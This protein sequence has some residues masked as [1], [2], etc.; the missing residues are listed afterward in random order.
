[1]TVTTLLDVVANDGE[2][3]LREAI[4]RVTDGTDPPGT[5]ITFDPGLAGGV[6]RLTQGELTLSRSMTIDGDLDGDGVPDI[7]LS[8]DAAGDDTTDAAGIT[9][10][11]ASAQA[12]TLTDNSRV[13]SVTEGPV[14]LTGLVITGGY[15]DL[16]GGIRNPVNAGGG[17]RLYADTTI[18]DSRIEG[19]GVAGYS[20]VGGGLYAAPLPAGGPLPALHI[21]D[22]TIA[23]NTATDSGG[24][25]GGIYIRAVAA[26]FADVAIDDN[27]AADDAGGIFVQGGSL[28]MTGGSLSG[29]ATAPGFGASGGGM[30]NRGFTRIDGTRIEDNTAG[31]DGGGL[32]LERSAGIANAT[33]E[34]N[35]AGGS[36]GGIHATDR[37]LVVSSAILGNS[38][39]QDG[40]GIRDRGADD[41]SLLLNTTV[42]GNSAGGDGGGLYVQGTLRGSP[43]T[44]Y[45]ATTR[46]VQSTVTG[47]HAGAEGGGGRIGSDGTIALVNS[48]VAGNGADDD[49]AEIA[50]PG[51]LAFE[52][53]SILGAGTLDADPGDNRLQPVVLRD[54]FLTTGTID[55]DATPGTGDEFEAGL[56]GDN[57]GGVPSVAIVGG[58]SLAVN[59]ADPAARIAGPATQISEADFGTDLTADGDTDDAFATVGDLVLEA[60]GPG[61]PRAVEGGIDLGAIETTLPD[62]PSLVVTTAADQVAGDGAISL[63]EAVG[64]VNQGA[65]APGATI[66]FAPA[67][68]GATLRL[69]GGE[70]EILAALAIDGDIDGDGVP[71][72]TITG[73]ALGNDATDAA[74]LTDIAASGE[75]LRA[76]NS[77][78]LHVTV[79]EA[80]L[81]L[82]GLVLTGGRAADGPGGAVN[83]G[84]GLV[85]ADSI[86]AGN[87]TTGDGAPGG[88][89][90]AA[91]RL[92]VI[93]STI[94]AN[95]T[96]GSASPG[97]GLATGGAAVVLSSTLS[98]NATRGPDSDGGGLHAAGAATAVNATV[99]ANTTAGT[100]SDGGG[101]AS[102]GPL[103]VLASTVTGN[104]VA[105]PQLAAGGGIAATGA[106]AA[107]IANSVI[108]GN[109]AA[110]AA[111][112]GGEIHAG[113][114]DFAGLSIVGADS[115]AFDA[116][117]SPG[118]I[119]A[120]PRDLFEG[121]A[122]AFLDADADGV[123]ETASGLIG[124][125]L[126]ANGGRAATVALAIDADNPARDSA[127][128]AVPLAIAE[129][130]ADFDANGTS[131]ETL[132]FS[133][134]VLGADLNGDGDLADSVATL[135]DLPA[136]ARGAAF[137]RIVGDGPD[138]GAFELQRALPVARDDAVT[139][140]AGRSVLIDV[141]GNDTDADGDALSLAAAG[142]GA[143]A[144]ANGA[145]AIEGAGVRY[146]PDAGFVGADS[147]LYRVEDGADGAAE[148][149]ATV[150]VQSGL[151]PAGFDGVIRGTGRDDLIAIAQNATYL[152]LAG[153]DT[154][155][156][157]PVAEA[158]ALSLVE[159]RA[160]D[161]LQLVGGLVVAG[162]RVSG[163]DLELTLANG[164]VVRVLNAGEMLFDV[165]GN[166]TAEQAGRLEDFDTFTGATLGVDPLSG[167]GGARV[168]GGDDPLGLG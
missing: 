66:T 141:L 143:G 63:R 160:E 156:L 142:A 32:F 82:T 10:I 146:T 71:D 51:T 124:G 27:R 157:S 150:V 54:V 45:S 3:S 31:G 4:A 103:G 115:G 87:A 23:G 48:I 132:A 95:A 90:F 33:I 167:T 26:G 84:A 158:E 116:G 55:P 12:G 49:G 136:D 166:A 37:F 168:I 165:A 83:A 76:D 100:G 64:F 147:F 91:A 42:A 99:G 36:G 108:L 30:F 120:P 131:G 109:A 126:A 69:I 105:D 56:P 18:G 28:M 14:T 8:G 75:A 35:A 44:Q 78:L 164:A 130:T 113:T 153:A 114:V 2:T 119:N 65:V 159:G 162:S 80:D 70:I 151:A 62:P 9:D 93:A 85:I 145:V 21:A 111:P 16:P 19:N 123:A 15:V 88:A 152:G 29:N 50:G 59:A 13:L 79:P 96:E 5:V 40:G 74:G 163:E 161:T 134:A 67:L 92:S 102:P 60:R 135:G 38:A 73:D 46:V 47:N 53:P 110:G 133:E 72:I 154:L 24:D 139:T 57:G 98:A 121:L 104:T 25:A 140:P 101:L 129:G 125:R 144:P 149:R 107:L 155:L 97:G 52:A 94:H 77:R 39:G 58:G 81:A 117:V 41:V 34:G 6:V 137:P 7:V 1:M 17:V 89:A 20:A 122:E 61:F 148:A 112:G 68:S 128:A 86:L 22:G 138:P 118:V 43:G 127:E 106:G 11:A